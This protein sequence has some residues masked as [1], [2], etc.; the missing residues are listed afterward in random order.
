LI[1]I[2]D[3]EWEQKP[4]F[5]LGLDTRYQNMKKRCYNST[6]K[7]YYNYGGRGI[8]ICDEWLND[9]YSFFLW[10]IENGYRPELEI[11][12]INNDEGYRPDNCRYIT[13]QENRN[14][15]RDSTNVD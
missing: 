8:Q 12:R 1:D 6:N 3:L 11:D 4:K 9:K 2:N 10:S 14:N 5:D 7:D 15:R 13:R